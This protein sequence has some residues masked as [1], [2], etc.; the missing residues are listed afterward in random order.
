MVLFRSQSRRILSCLLLATIL[1]SCAGTV[2]AAPAQPAWP[3]IRADSAVVIDYDTG[4]VLYQKNPDAM[5]VPASMTKVMTAYIIFE[6]LK[7]GA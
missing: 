6:E 3:N 5:M 1:L 2:S 4:E 7:P